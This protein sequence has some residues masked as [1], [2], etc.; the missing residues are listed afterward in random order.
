MA[1]WDPTL[2][3]PTLA[4]APTSMSGM[5]GPSMGSV[6]QHHGVIGIVL[7]AAL[8]LV[9]LNQLGFRFAVTAGRR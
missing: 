9:A 4:S 1:N 3:T 8:V 6:Q 5:G 2:V 7:L